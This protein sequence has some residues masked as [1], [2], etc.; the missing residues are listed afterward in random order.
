MGYEINLGN[1][2]WATGQGGMAMTVTDTDTGV[3]EAVLMGCDRNAP[4]TA[5]NKDGLLYGVL[6][7]EPSVTYVDGVGVLNNESSATNL[8]QYSEDFSQSI[9]IKNQVSFGEEINSIIKNKQAQKLVEGNNIGEHY[10]SYSYLSSTGFVTFS[11]YAKKGERRFLNLAATNVGVFKAVFDLENGVIVD[12]SNSGANIQELENGWYRCS[13][14][15]NVAS[16][17]G[18]AFKIGVSD[19]NSIPSGGSTNSYQGNGVSGVYVTGA[20]IEQGSIATS[21]IPTNGFTETRLADT[22]FQTPDISKW[23]DSESFSFEFSCSL[24]IEGITQIVSLFNKSNGANNRIEF[25]FSSATSTIKCYVIGNGSVYLNNV[26]ITTSLD[27]ALENKYRVDLISGV[28][29]FYINDVLEYTSSGGVVFD[30]LGG[31]ALENYNSTSPLYA[32]VKN[33]KIES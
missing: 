8:I 32:H 9:W 26:N 24:L 25:I 31:L 33:I 7:Y 2:A 20:Q 30:N 23:I 11:I 4:K 21:Y 1:G 14:L 5:V 17:G 10:I 22:G 18:V 6:P 12:G 19:S 29:Y 28:L 16:T 15:K 27:R 13:F 3:K